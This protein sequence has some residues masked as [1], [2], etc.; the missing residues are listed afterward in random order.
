MAANFAKAA[1]AEFSEITSD[2]VCGRAHIATGCCPV[3]AIIT[4]NIINGRGL[5]RIEYGQPRGHRGVSVSWPRHPPPRPQACKGEPWSRA[6]AGLC[7]CESPPGPP[8]SP[9][10][11]AL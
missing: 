10:T 4:A 7:V 2:E 9:C 6:S 5:Q 11:F 3:V 1:G 8:P